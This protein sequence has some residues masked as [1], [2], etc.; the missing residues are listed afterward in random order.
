MNVEKAEAVATI[1]IKVVVTLGVLGAWLYTTVGSGPV[2]DGLDT[3]AK[4]VMGAVF[5]TALSA[6]VGAIRHRISR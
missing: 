5:G 6:G 1:V 2:P 4:I 3:A